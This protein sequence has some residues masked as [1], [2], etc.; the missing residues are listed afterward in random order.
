MK[1]YGYIE[2]IIFVKE[3]AK[4]K[5]ALHPNADVTDFKAWR[6]I[7]NE[8][9]DGLQTYGEENINALWQRFMI[10]WAQLRNTDKVKQ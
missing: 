5:W 3:F 10:E 6:N 7:V 9:Y 2:G 4:E 8:L 1:R